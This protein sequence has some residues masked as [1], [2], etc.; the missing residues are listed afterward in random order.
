MRKNQKLKTPEEVADYYESH[1]THKLSGQ[2]VKVSVDKDLRTLI[3]IRLSWN[4]IKLIKA[5][6]KSRGVA[7]QSLIQEWLWEKVESELTKEKNL[8]LEIPRVRKPERVQNLILQSEEAY[9][10]G[11]DLK[12]D[13]NVYASFMDLL[14]E[15]S[16]AEL[17]VI[18]KKIH[19]CLEQFNEILGEQ[20]QEMI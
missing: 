1:S 18:D 16:E 11:Y 17:T 2:S 7:Y 19:D 15:L 8:A 9:R 6:G 3:S 4:L 20:D 10:I 12:N 13:E 14:P 5:I